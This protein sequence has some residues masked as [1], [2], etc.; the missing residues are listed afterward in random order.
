MKRSFI[1][2]A[3]SITLAVSL[4]VPG[5]N[6]YQPSVAQA[7][8]VVGWI[9][10]SQAALPSINEDDTNSTGV[11]VSELLAG[12]VSNPSN[13]GIA[14]VGMDNA[15][16]AWQYYHTGARLWYNIEPVSMTSSFLL[17]N[18]ARIRF[19]PARDWNGTATITYK[20][21]DTLMYGFNYQKNVDTLLFPPAFSTETGSAQITVDPVNDAPYLVEPQG[22]DYLKFDGNGDYVTIPDFRL[23]GGSFTVE[24]NL[25]VDAFTTWMRFFDSSVGMDNYNVFVGFNGKKMNFVAKAGPIG[26]GGE[27]QVLED[28]PQ[29]KWVHVAIVYDQNQNKGLIYWDGVLKAAGT[30]KL[31][32]AWDVARPNNWLG[33]STWMQDG[34]FTGGMKDVRFWSKAKSQEEIV[35]DKD[36]D[37]TGG[38]PDLFANYK[39]NNRNDQTIAYSTPSSLGNRNGT[40]TGANWAQYAGF[41]GMTVTDKNIPAEREFK[42]IDPEGDAVMASAVSSNTALVPNS[43]LMISGSGDTRVL[44][45][46]PAVNVYGTTTITVTT[47]DGLLSNAYSFILQVRDTGETVVTGVTLNQTELN[48]TVG[49]APETLVA[50]VEP[51]DATN[52]SVIWSTS[53]ETVAQV[54]NGIVTPVG[55]GIAIISATTFDGN[56]T[57]TAAV[58]VAAA[59]TVPG[60]PENVRAAAGDGQATVSF[61][62]PVSDGGSPI[63][64]YRVIAYPGGHEAT[65]SVSPISITGL[66][67][68]TAYT[69]SVVAMN[70]AG[71]SALSAPSAS[72]TPTEQHTVPDAPPAPILSPATAGNAQ[73]ALEWSP[74]LGAAGF[75]VYQSEA[76]GHPGTEIATVTGSTYNYVAAGL[77]NGKTYYFT[78]KA[79]NTGGDSPASNQ[80]SAIPATVPSAP[81]NVRAVAG[82]GQATVSFNPPASTGGSPITGYEV[83][84]QPGNIVT[85][86]ASSPITVAGLLNGTSYTFTVRAI[87]AAGS[88]ASSVESNAVIPDSPASGGETPSEPS[89]PGGSSGS[90]GGTG[91][92]P[93]Q[94][95]QPSTPQTP[96]AGVD[97]LVNGK[98]ENAGIASSSQRNNQTVITVIVDQNKLESKLAAEGQHAVVTIP[99]HG[100]Y[101]VVV[102]ELNGQMVKNMESKQAVLEI[103][104][105]HATYTLPAEQIN[106]DAVSEQ[107]GG[108]IALQDIKL[109]VEIAT[110]DASMLKVVEN[111][112]AEGTFTMLV[113]PVE[114]TVRGVYGDRV[115]EVSKFNAYVERT[116]AIPDGV[117]ASK[118]T[119][120]VIVDP[121]GS[122]RHVPTRVVQIDGK[123]YARINSLTNSTYSVVWHPVEFKDAAEHW[124]KDTVN[125]MGSRMVVEGMG[126]DM[127]NPNKNITR[128][129]FAAIVVRG[130]GLKPENGPIAF[131]DVTAADWYNNAVATASAYGLISGFEDGTFRPKE[132]ITREQSMVIIAKAMKITNLK[133]KLQQQPATADTVLSP[134]G[135]AQ[136]TSAWAQASLVNCLQA[137]IVS[138]RSS[139]ELAAKSYI[140]RAEVAAIVQRLLQKSDLI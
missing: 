126:N 111:A 15:N 112:A 32:P 38:E 102:G 58:N 85:T 125:D 115:V 118:I 43:G 57:A 130:L 13:T 34:D 37:L 114:F 116:M 93:T 136:N 109:Q 6:L 23:Y 84:A 45:I 2:I 60:A 10:N 122:V 3:A 67:N 94:P 12:K 54:V 99:V 65:G 69:F 98:V 51:A 121:D 74:V 135:D 133:A 71:D 27:V 68:G 104:T 20:L 107:I 16:G 120:G 21:W 90:S 26:T 8:S 100:N 80:V 59:V 41:F 128:A 47:S 33:K 134:Y 91:Q 66:D 40:I 31:T 53:D 76:S 63:T 18:T 108:K 5:A 55:P 19:V 138:G 17:N 124:A 7:A 105:D 39:L 49:D 64:G 119:T 73:V 75:K 110:P 78:V 44:S 22:G 30:M 36:L 113:P 129:E 77:T 50:T 81:S 140:T 86:G 42:V 95:V 132:S 82:N 97:I 25:K 1:K 9:D 48:L 87:N 52:P 29:D 96:S 106:I 46:T 70:S 117:D 79:T 83:I 101:D 131:S 11:A 28:F 137:G 103:K 89:Q 139:T 72:V 4:V 61:D 24:G 62:P 127:F 123:Y 56:Y 35:R 14:I 92:A 88:S